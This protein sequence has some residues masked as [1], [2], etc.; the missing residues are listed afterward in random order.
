MIPDCTL[1]TAC[2]NFSNIHKFSR[3]F[4]E[5][6]N[7][8]KKLLEIPCYLCIF[9]DNYC[10]DE[11]KKIR[12]SFDLDELTHYIIIDFKIINKKIIIISLTLLKV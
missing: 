6:I 12:Q 4:D 8:M 9:T 2:Y 10:I 7:N 1:T 11:I 3:T 5:C